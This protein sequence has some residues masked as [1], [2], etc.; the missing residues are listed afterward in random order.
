MGGGDVAVTVVM[1]VAGGGGGLGSPQQQRSN[2]NDNNRNNCNNCNN[3][4]NNNN[5]DNRNNIIWPIRATTQ[6]CLIR[7]RHG[8]CGCRGASPRNSRLPGNIRGIGFE[9]CGATGKY[10]IRGAPFALL[11][12]NTRPKQVKHMSNFGS[13]AA[14]NGKRPYTS[15]NKT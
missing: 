4:S 1:A 14:L 15:N 2:D 5:N 8:I 12:G 10:Q 13:G 6:R 9:M 7:G 11:V 3:C